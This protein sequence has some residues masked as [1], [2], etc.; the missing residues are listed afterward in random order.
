MLRQFFKHSMLY[1]I[2]NILTKGVG[3]LLIPVY[4]SF[5]SQ[6]EYGVLDYIVS[7]GAVAAVVVTFEISQG[8]MR[9][10]SELQGQVR[11]QAS[12]VATAFWFTVLCYVLLLLVT[13]LFLEDLSL[14]LLEEPGR[15]RTLFFGMLAFSSNAL[16]Y[17]ISVVYRSKL[18]PLLSIM[19]S[20]GSVTS[21]ALFSFCALYVG[22]GV[23]GL[24]L[25]QFLAQ[26]F[27]VVSV[28][29]CCHKDFLKA[30]DFFRL[31]ELLSFSVPL[32]AS[33]LSVIVSMFSDRLFIKAFL[34]FQELAVFGVGAKVASV[35]TLV[36]MGVQSAL[37]PL[38]YSRLSSADTRATL[39]KIM[40]GYIFI[41]GCFLSFTAFLGEELVL[42]IAGANYSGA[43]SVAVVLSAAVLVQGMCVFFPGL[44]I[45][46]RTKLLAVIN[47]LGAMFSIFL[48]FIFVR[49][50]GILGAS[51]ATFLGAFLIFALNA[52]FSQKYYNFF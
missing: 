43:A 30:P 11:L 28:V 9:Y 25:A 48:N 3:F 29:W 16:V 7:V 14:L 19:V 46:K 37:A 52:F 18:K 40:A 20:L 35:V 23:G 26:S 1:S 39:R 33:S 47:V 13:L 15:E 41:G 8:V 45:F 10:V 42:I 21:V 4:L 34:G 36:T 12:Y 27:V 38:V 17:L 22:G 32:V 31:K 51:F 50:W 2:G 6:E 44:S 49:E 5:L 24:L